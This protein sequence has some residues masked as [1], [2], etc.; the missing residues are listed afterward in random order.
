MSSFVSRN[1]PQQVQVRQ[2]TP[3]LFGPDV[4]VT[5]EVDDRATDPRTF[6]ELHARFRFDLDVAASHANAKCERYYTLEDDGLTCSWAGA[7]VWCNPPYSDIRPW[8]E[9]ARRAA[10]GDGGAEFVV[11][12]L[13]AN[14]TEQGWWHDLV[15]PIRD[16]PGRG[17]RTEFLRGRREFIQPS[18]VKAH[19]PFGCVLLIWQRPI[20]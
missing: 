1:H 19:V 8:V 3:A 20:A 6:D 18:G 10:L 2:R 17:L 13:P 11:M 15:E 12:L 7:R 16:Q 4:D 9:K 5:D 14:R